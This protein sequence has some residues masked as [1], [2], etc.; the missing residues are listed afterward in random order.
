MLNLCSADTCRL[1]L[2]PRH[3]YNGVGKTLFR[4]AN[5]G[6]D[7]KEAGQEECSFSSNISSE[8]PETCPAGTSNSPSFQ[9]EAFSGYSLKTMPTVL[10]LTAEKEGAAHY[11]YKQSLYLPWVMFLEKAL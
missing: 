10:T 9:Q 6:S 8:W 7:H 11:V 3:V 4:W 1:L 5:P 2:Q